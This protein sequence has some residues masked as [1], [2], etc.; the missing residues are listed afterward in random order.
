MTGVCRSHHA[1]SILKQN[2]VLALSTP[3]QVLFGFPIE[4][5]PYAKEVYTSKRFVMHASYLLQMLD[6]AL[7][8]LGPDIDL[9][10]EM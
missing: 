5:D 7:N 8:M 10:T 3:F 1:L 4:I 2:P 9:L 6:T